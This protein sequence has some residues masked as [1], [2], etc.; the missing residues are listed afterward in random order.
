MISIVNPC[1]L[2]GVPAL[3]IGRFV[4]HSSGC[5]A[6][7]NSGQL[8]AV[9]AFREPIDWVPS[10]AAASSTEVPAASSALGAA[11]V[12]HGPQPAMAALAPALLV[13]ASLSPFSAKLSGRQ[14]A[15]VAAAAPQG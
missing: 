12:E 7:T 10:S 2:F 5:Q 3:S 14:V 1:Q 9:L 6:V 4:C 13:T 8:Q 15:A 11:S